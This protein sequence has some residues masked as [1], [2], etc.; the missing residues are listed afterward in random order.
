MDYPFTYSRLGTL[1]NV[2][3][4]G[5]VPDNAVSAGSK[6]VTYV[7]ER[8]SKSLVAGVLIGWICSNAFWLR[9]FPTR[10]VMNSDLVIILSTIH[11]EYIVIIYKKE[12]FKF[13]FTWD[14]IFLVHQ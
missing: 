10:R 7:R 5:F 12:S 11:I 1:C 2:D 14:R 4:P 3:S 9:Y 13:H 8:L 6:K